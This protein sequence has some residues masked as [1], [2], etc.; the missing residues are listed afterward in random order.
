MNSE[1]I[2]TDFAERHFDPDFSGT[3]LSID[4]NEFVEIVNNRFNFMLKNPPSALNN[5]IRVYDGYAPFCKL[6][7]IDNPLNNVRVGTA[8]ITLENSQYLKSGYSTRKEGE[9]PVLSR[10]LE[11]PER[12][13][14]PNAKYLIVVL[15]DVNQLE[16]E[17]YSHGEN[18]HE[19]FVKNFDYGVVAIL[20]QEG[21]EEE[22]MAPM[23]MIRNSMD[24]KY[25]GSGVEFNEEK[26]NKSVEFWSTHAIVK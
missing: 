4:K 15:Y 25:G 24:T 8:K 7:S 5:D 3:R 18:K 17:F 14:I 11:Y 12:R 10:W 19:V 6:L 26:Y 16:K 21:Y 23:T 13:F 20:A 9:F 1:I 22:P 2:L